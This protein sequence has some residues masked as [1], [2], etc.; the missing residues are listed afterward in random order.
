MLNS[1]TH[2]KVAPAD[3]QT[4]TWQKV[5]LPYH[6]D[7][8]RNNESTIVGKGSLTSKPLPFIC[9]RHKARGPHNVFSCGP[10]LCISWLKS[11][12]PCLVDHFIE[13]L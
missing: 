13:Y 7:G 4:K 8:E 9:R 12:I 2:C 11:G 10:L 6:T 3:T 5:C 1:H